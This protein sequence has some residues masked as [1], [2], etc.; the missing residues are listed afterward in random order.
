MK[1]N[2]SKALFLCLGVFSTVSYAANFVFLENQYGAEIFCKVQNNNRTNR[3]LLINNKETRIGNGVRVCLGVLPLDPKLRAAWVNDVSIKTSR[4]LSALSS[5]SSLNNYMDKIV[6]AHIKCCSM[7][8][9]QPFCQQQ[10]P[11]NKDVIV[12]I[13]PSNIASQWDVTFRWENQNRG[14]IDFSMDNF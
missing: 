10:Q 13:R 12:I 2:V 1:S 9:N 4:Y 5:Y 6:D 14:S 3:N 7:R 11:C 8:M